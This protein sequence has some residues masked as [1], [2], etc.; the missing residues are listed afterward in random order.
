MTNN[1][2]K[3]AEPGA[4][5]HNALLS[6]EGMASARTA[7]SNLHSQFLHA[8]RVDAFEGIKGAGR[9]VSEGPPDART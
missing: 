7:L 1:G 6:P 4:A 9:T 3:E 5:L 2:A 8:S